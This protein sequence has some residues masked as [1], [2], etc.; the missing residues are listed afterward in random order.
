MRLVLVVAGL[1]VGV[2]LG[3]ALLLV[4]PMLLLQPAPI[5]LSGAVHTLAWEAGEGFRGFELTPRGLLGA[6]DRRQPPRQFAEPG[7]R[8]ARAEV[9]RLAADE[10]LPPALGVRLS[11]ISDHDS[12]LQARLG[13]VTQWN[14]VWPQRG[15]V[16]LAGS[17]NFWRP[18]RDGL[19][20]AVRGRGFRPGAVR[21]ILPPFPA[22]GGNA[23]GAGTGEFAAA[24]M[25]FREE[26]S[27]LEDRAGAFSGQRRLQ[28]ALD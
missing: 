3:I 21:Y 27:P 6:G 26:L 14:L 9:V 13:V 24:R 15:T 2:F 12:L 1:C 7:I 5:S 4:N 20:S 18:L 28:L 17:E 8:Y 22:P 19:W 10:E 25:A 23:F 16:L 11:A